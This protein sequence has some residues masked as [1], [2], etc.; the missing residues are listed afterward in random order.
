[1]S[2]HTTLREANIA[3]EKLWENPA[4]PMSLSYLGNAC[5]GEMG[6]ACNVI[7]KL[8]REVLG[9]AGSRDTVEHLGEELAD[10]L[11]YIDIIALR[12]GIDL[13]AAVARK[14][15]KTSDQVGFDVKIK[16][17]YSGEE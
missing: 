15:N 1:M 16:R 4:K 2:T 17:R 8:D 9:M 12:T 6:E 11:I 14:F 5:A 3:R 7:K 10:V 13:E